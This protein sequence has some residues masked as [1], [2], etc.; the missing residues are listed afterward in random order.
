M[1]DLKFDRVS[2]KYKLRAGH[3]SPK[4]WYRPAWRNRQNEMWALRDVSF[5]VREGESLGIVGHNGAGKTTILK[6]L[7]SITAPSAGEITVRGKLAALVE[8]SSGFHPELTGRENVYLHGAMLGMRRSEIKRK[9]DSIIE[10]SGVENYIDVPVKRYSSGMFVRLGFAIAAHL[11][12]DILLLDEVL[13][14]GD[15]AFQAKCL[16]R[17]AELRKMGR[18]LVFISHDLAAVYRVCD[19]A[20]LLNHGRLLMDGP[21]RRVID[22]YQTMTFAGEGSFAHGGDPESLAECTHVS[23]FGRDGSD[24]VRTGYPMLAQL[25]YRAHT[26]IDDVVFRISIYWPSGYLCAELS[27]ESSH[28]GLFLERGAGA[29]EFECPVVPVVPGLYRVDVA[30]QSKGRDI[31]LRQRCA[32]LRVEPGRPVAGDFYIENTWKLS[33]EPSAIRQKFLIDNDYPSPPGR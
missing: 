13:A 12:P 27:T 21:P 24:E 4:R 28:H 23:F 10:F 18:T 2:K 22:E 30:I 29:V 6:I 15:A 14:V 25:R 1:I 5:E 32:T 17:I 31:D 9:L 7:S 20:L 11:D 33:P 3:N 26:T 16:D 8:V 19:R